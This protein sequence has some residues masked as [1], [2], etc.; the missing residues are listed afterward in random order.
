MK[1]KD[2][3]VTQ[4]TEVDGSRKAGGHVLV[5]TWK[6]WPGDTYT[7]APMFQQLLA[8]PHHHTTKH[9]PSA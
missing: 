6:H 9:F 1:V 8:R 7:T 5:L 3:G 2:E 4:E